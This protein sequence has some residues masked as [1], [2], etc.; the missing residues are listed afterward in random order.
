MDMCNSIKKNNF[1]VIINISCKCYTRS[2][3]R[4]SYR[5]GR[6]PL[7]LIWN[8]THKRN[9]LQRRKQKCRNTDAIENT[10]LICRNVA[11]WCNSVHMQ[12]K[13]KSVSII[14]IFTTYKSRLKAFGNTFSP[15]AP[16]STWEC[17]EMESGSAWSPLPYSLWLWPWS[18]KCL[19]TCSR[20]LPW[21]VL[22]LIW[23]K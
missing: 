22:L 3:L 6:N 10:F 4:S 11:R 7:Q 18:C 1:I 2:S 15:L 14:R 20:F 5:H 8:I 16:N 12:P 19:N 21:T 23:S 13:G 17:N 9:H